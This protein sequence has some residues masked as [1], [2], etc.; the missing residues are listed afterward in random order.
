MKDGPWV[1]FCGLTRL[2]DALA[3]VELGVDA[4]GFVLWPRSPRHIS[5]E[6][7]ARI[8]TQLPDTV[9]RV[10]VF[11]DTDVEAAAAVARDARLTAVQ[12]HGGA[13]P[14]QLAQAGLPVLVAASVAQHEQNPLR[15]A[16]A[17]D[18]AWPRSVTLL[19]DAADAERRG[20][21]GQRA[22]WSFA[23]VLSSRRRI[24]LAGG[25][26][27]E[28]VEEALLQ[29]Q[30][31]GVDV[32]S[33]IESAPGIKDAQR[34]DAFVRAVREAAASIPGTP[35]ATTWGDGRGERDG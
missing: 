21:T 30:P 22:N 31:F 7:V 28:T 26:S 23:R 2:E 32:S 11:V 3:A 16:V 27:A 10:G 5:P 6:A 12:L 17:C 13:S 35:S 25:L 1:K 19:V 14:E 8:S 18:E 33:G 20:G 29:V 4:L 15:A 9:M 34:M 24:V